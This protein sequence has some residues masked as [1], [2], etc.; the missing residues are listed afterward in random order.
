MNY[1]QFLNMIPEF[2]LVLTLLAVFVVDFIMH[3]SEKKLDV[4]FSVTAAL[5]IVLPVRIAL[6][7]EPA[8]AFGGMYV[9]SQAANVMKIILT[10]GALIVVIMAQ[11][12]LKNEASK[13]AGEF[14][15]LI[16]ST[17]LGMY[18]MMSSGSPSIS[19]WQLS[20][21]VSCYMAFHL[22]TLLQVRSIS[23]MLLRLSWAATRSMR[24]LHH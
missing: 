9:A 17:L 16:L 20:Q 7:A 1:G 18:V 13:Y 8:E 22:S 5:L 19:S 3:R 4:L 12:W 21:V 15:L 11:P 24:G 10:I 6:L 23:V 2:Y 14:Y